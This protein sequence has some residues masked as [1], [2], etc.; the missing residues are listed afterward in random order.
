MSAAPGQIWIAKS[1]H[2]STHT[3]LRHGRGR[4][5]VWPGIVVTETRSDSSGW[6]GVPQLGL[7]SSLSSPLAE[8]MPRIRRRVQGS[9]EEGGSPM[10]HACG[11]R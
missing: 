9:P 2:R 1:C 3:V 7:G 8:G 10:K 5:W 11:I 6:L 4:Q